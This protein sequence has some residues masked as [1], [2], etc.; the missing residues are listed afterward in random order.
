VRKRTR[1]NADEGLQRL[2]SAFGLWETFKALPQ[3]VRAI[4]RDMRR[5]R[6]RVAWG[7][8]GPRDKDDRAAKALVERVMSTAMEPCVE[9][10]GLILVQDLFAW[11]WPLAQNL[12][13]LS[14][15]PEC[16][17]EPGLRR[18]AETLAPPRT[19]R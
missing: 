15:N 17:G 12:P 19:W 4:I 9:A 2:P 18:M 16:S 1:S 3:P 10:S 14:G 13:V 5:P 8:D 7:W 6:L 11:G